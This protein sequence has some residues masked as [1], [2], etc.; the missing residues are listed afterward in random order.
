MDSYREEQKIFQKYIY[1]LMQNNEQIL[2]DENGYL[3]GNHPEIEHLKNKFNVMEILIKIR[4][5]SFLKINFYD[6][7]IGGEKSDFSSLESL[8]NKIFEENPDYLN[9]DYT[10]SE[11]NPCLYVFFKFFIFNSDKSN[12]KE[13][14]LESL[15]KLNKNSIINQRH[16]EIKFNNK[17][18][19]F[20]YNYL[21]NFNY[22]SELK[23]IFIGFDI[24]KF[25][26]DFVLF[27]FEE[28]FLKNTILIRR[29]IRRSNE[30]PAPSDDILITRYFLQKNN[31]YIIIFNK[32]I[33]DIKLD[34]LSNN[35]LQ[36][37]IPFLKV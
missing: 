16:F 32:F 29:R 18:Y 35:E 7:F 26:I 4:K 13:L 23:E 3:F 31:E 14:L 37:I 25:I 11:Y 22:T 36:E 27:F 5:E 20:Y 15:K 33:E 1:N 2:S 30:S 28:I 19:S 17:T 24:T 6:D 12:L 8:L 10:F 21:E 34:I 9:E